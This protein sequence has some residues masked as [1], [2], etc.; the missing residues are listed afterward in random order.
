[1]DDDLV[2]GD[3]GSESAGNLLSLTAYSAP[4]LVLFGCCFLALGRVS[5]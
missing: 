2:D 1:M 4:G 3:K 5:G